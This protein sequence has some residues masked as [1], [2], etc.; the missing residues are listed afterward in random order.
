MNK[1]SSHIMGH[2]IFVC[3]LWHETNTFSPVETDHD[4][5]A[6]CVDLAGDRMASLAGSNT[7]VG[8]MIDA[9]RDFSFE[10]VFGR[11]AGAFP[12]KPMAA[13]LFNELTGDMLARARRAGPLNGALVALHG[14][15]VAEGVDEADADFMERLREQLGPDTPIVCTFDYHA[16][17]SAR[18]V[19]AVDILVGYRTNP[20]IDMRDRGHEAGSLMNRLLRGERFYKAFRKLPM[21][22][23]SQT[24][25]TADEPMR[26]V[27]ALLDA[28]RQLPEVATASI[29]V[30][31]PY[32]DIATLGMS[33]VAYARSATAA[34]AT[35]DRLATALWQ[36]RADFIAHVIAPEIA[37]A[38][39][40]AASKLRRP[41]ILVDVADN[42]GGG[43][44][45]D[46]TTLLRELVRAKAP[47][48]VVVLT[49]PEAARLAARTGVGNRFFGQVGGKTDRLHG[50]PVELVGVVSAIR[51]VSYIRGEE[52]MTGQVAIQGL[53][54]RISVEGIEV[55]VTE[56][57]TLP[58]DRMHLTQIGV[59]P[60][61]TGILVVKAAAGWRTPF[62]AM[63][64]EAIYC[65]TPGV[66]APDLAHFS[67]TR[68]PKPL[69]P[70]E[71]DTQWNLQ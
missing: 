24:Q 36:C 35:V 21:V 43:S 19:A 56:H 63:M 53:T 13:D 65:D 60:A 41:V 10:V 34:D 48:A 27:M 50:E 18:L 57:R 49:D 4:S 3:G 29:A 44:P 1:S 46:A 42:I 52:W 5:V 66:N 38:N 14:A 20:H 70:L 62:E 23:V 11:F 47:S 59:D 64:A 39:A 33:A 71:L 9:A 6:A 15:M 45:G 7:E 25:V 22:S 12:S 17:L 61:A 40:I 37:V 2:R 30:G 26:S 8:G 28:G 51:D 32:A 16:N 69:Y 55:I 58:Y 31:Y 54:A 67:Y 68:R